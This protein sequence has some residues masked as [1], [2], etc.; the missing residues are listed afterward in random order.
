MAL[1]RKGSAACFQFRAWP[2]NNRNISRIQLSAFIE[3][4]RINPV[5]FRVAHVLSPG[6]IDG[7]AAY[8]A[9]LKSEAARRRAGEPGGG[10]KGNFREW[11]S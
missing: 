4:R 11:H 5:M 9:T 6:M 8:F 7:L 3:K 2:D 10:W 1:R